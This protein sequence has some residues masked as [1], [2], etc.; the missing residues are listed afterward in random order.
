MSVTV[1][2]INHFSCA[3]SRIRLSKEK[4]LLLQQR[5]IQ[6]RIEDIQSENTKARKKK[7]NEEFA[8]LEMYVESTDLNPV[9]GENEDNVVEEWNVVLYSH[10]E[11]ED[12]D[13]FY[14]DPLFKINGRNCK[15]CG[16]YIDDFNND[17]EVYRQ[18]IVENGWDEPHLQ[19]YAKD[20]NFFVKPVCIVCKCD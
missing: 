9:P 18:F 19:P 11:E 2:P 8:R 15:K 4:S 10:T 1:M 14:E 16:D 13:Y 5:R 20:L 3:G 6:S 12:E 17:P 7:M